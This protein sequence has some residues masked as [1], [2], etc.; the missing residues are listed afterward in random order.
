MV[1]DG[2]KLRT[3]CNTNCKLI[4]IE[5]AGTDIRI[6]IHTSGIELRVQRYTHTLMAPIFKRESSAFH[7]GKKSQEMIL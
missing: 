2:E 6:D 1:E 7:E 3:H 4:I 5:S